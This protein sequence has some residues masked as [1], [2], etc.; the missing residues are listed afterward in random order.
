MAETMLER[1]L[2]EFR[3]EQLPQVTEVR[4]A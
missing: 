2:R 1:A 3:G 4:H